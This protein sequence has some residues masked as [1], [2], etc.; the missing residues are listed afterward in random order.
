QPVALNGLAQQLVERQ[1]VGGLGPAADA[2]LDRGQLLLGTPG[3][4]I[5]AREG[6][7]PVVEHADPQLELRTVAVETF[8]LVAYLLPRGRGCQVGAPS[9]QPRPSPAARSPTIR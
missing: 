3:E 9:P 2:H 1:L 6:G 7:Q 4:R 5:P 8:Q